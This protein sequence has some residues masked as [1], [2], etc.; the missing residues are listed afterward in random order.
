MGQY[1]FGPIVN[2]TT[3]VGDTILQFAIVEFEN[4]SFVESFPCGGII[5]RNVFAELSHKGSP[6]LAGLIFQRLVEAGAPVGT[7]AHSVRYHSVA[8]RY[9]GHSCITLDP[10]LIRE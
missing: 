10:R 4:C 1:F 5:R 6:F 8:V 3:C 7:L 9:Y 2:R